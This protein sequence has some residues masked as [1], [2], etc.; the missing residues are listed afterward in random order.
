VHEHCENLDVK[1]EDFFTYDQA[2]IQERA[3]EMAQQES[4]SRNPGGSEGLEAFMSMPKVDSN[5]IY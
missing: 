1:Q 2:S 4:S 3:F 5:N